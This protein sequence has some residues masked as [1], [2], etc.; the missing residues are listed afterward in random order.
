MI[1]RMTR[2]AFGARS[3]KVVAPMT[4]AR[5]QFSADHLA[6]SHLEELKQPPF[7]SWSPASHPPPEEP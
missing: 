2:T 5:R 6:P 7:R 1:S 3:S 4:A